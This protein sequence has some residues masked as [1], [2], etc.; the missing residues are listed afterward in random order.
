[1]AITVPKTREELAKMQADAGVSLPWRE[2]TALLAQP[3]Q[4][5]AKTVPN[6][7]CYQAM[8]GCVSSSGMPEGVLSHPSIA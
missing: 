8:E 4:V 1:M 2:E 3:L 5:G 6:R 7:I